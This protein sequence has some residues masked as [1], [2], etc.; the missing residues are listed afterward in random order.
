MKYS[1]TKWSSKWF[2]ISE[3][4]LYYH[5]EQIKKLFPGAKIWFQSLVPLIIQNQFSVK[6]FHEYNRPVFEVCTYTKIFNLNV[7]GMFLQ[8]DQNSQ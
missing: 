3:Q 6:S 1:S 7:F 5:I 8:F 4:I 2:K